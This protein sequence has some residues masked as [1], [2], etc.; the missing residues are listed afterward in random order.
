MAIFGGNH[1]GTR[2]GLGRADG[3]KLGLAKVEWV[4]FRMGSGYGYVRWM[5]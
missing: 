3:V 2:S 5:W 4:G 1:F